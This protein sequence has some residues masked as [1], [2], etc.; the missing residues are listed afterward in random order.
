MP[1]LSASLDAYL[2]TC[3][4]ISIPWIYLVARSTPKTP[5]YPRIRPYISVILLLHT[6]YILHAILVA[7]PPNIFTS[8][9]IPLNTSTDQI[10]RILAKL[11][12]IDSQFALAPGTF[13]KPLEALLKRLSSFDTRTLYVRFGQRV[14]QTCEYC[15]TYDEYALYALPGPL[16]A[17]IQEAALIGLVTI[18]GTHRERWRTLG[19]GA[20]VAAAVLEGWYISTVPIRIP[21]KGEKTGVVMWHDVLFL[22]RQVLFLLLPVL[23]HILPASALSAQN[24]LTAIPTLLPVLESALTRLRFLKFT[25][26]AIMRVPAL[27]EKAGQWWEEERTDGDLVLGDERVRNVA[28]KEGYGFGPFSEEGEPSKLKASARLAVES[29]LRGGLPPSQHWQPT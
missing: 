5:L 10:R 29:F 1:L 27:R 28:E 4:L 22:F 26:G 13:P 19:V 25:R 11:G 6:L 24:P 21:R 16:L 2:V 18:R 20:V 15:Q 17:Y 9:D 7:P 3:S 8:L 23:L 12:G 14:L